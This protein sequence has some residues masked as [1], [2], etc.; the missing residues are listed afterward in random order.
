MAGDVVLCGESESER[1]RGGR[2]VVLEG[3]RG[4]SRVCLVCWLLSQHPT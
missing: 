2:G 1:E 4:E 3:G